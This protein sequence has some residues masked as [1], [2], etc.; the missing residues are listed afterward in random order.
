MGKVTKINSSR[1]EFKCNKCRQIIPKGSTYFR[2]EINFGPTIIRCASCGLKGYEVTT[3][4]YVM[5]AGE[6]VEDWSESYDASEEG[7]QDIIDA[8]NELRDEL[9]DRLDNMPYQLQDADTGMMLQDR[10]SC[11]E[12]A[13]SELENIDVDSL[14]SDVISDFASNM[15]FDDEDC[16]YSEED[17]EDWDT[18]V[19]TLDTHGE[20]EIVA[21]LESDLESLI[22]DA[23]S[24]A[25][26]CIE[27]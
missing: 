3:S 15:D 12:D 19:D 11:L 10:I 5:R 16:E 27:Y 24:E 14:K 2:G 23:I 20:L 21:E 9:Q 13:V 1:K 22:T 7:I 6:I 18:A 4:D 26:S 25:L 8:V 17:F